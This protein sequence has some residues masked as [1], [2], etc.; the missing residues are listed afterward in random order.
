MRIAA[1]FRRGQPPGTELWDHF[2]R[3]WP[4]WAK[5][6]V[7]Y[8]ATSNGQIGLIPTILPHTV[9]AAKLP[10]DFDEMERDEQQDAMEVRW[11]ISDNIADICNIIGL[12]AVF[13]V[14]SNL[15]ESFCVSDPTAT[16]N[17]E[18]E[19]TMER[20]YR[21]EA[22]LF[23]LQSGPR[24]DPKERSM[25]G[26]HPLLRLF[27][28]LR[29][30]PQHF[31]I[32]RSSIHFIAAHL[33][34]ICVDDE[35][36]EFLY[37]F[38]MTALDDTK[39]QREAVRAIRAFCVGFDATALPR[40]FIVSLFEIYDQK[41]HRLAVKDQLTLIEAMAL[42]ISK[43]RD[44][45][46]ARQGVERLLKK[47]RDHLVKL[48]QRASTEKLAAKD[49]SLDG[50]TLY[51]TVN[52]ISQIFKFFQPDYKAF[53]EGK[54]TDNGGSSSGTGK[55]AENISVKLLEEIW[56][57]IRYILT[58]WTECDGVMEKTTRIIKHVIRNGGATQF[59]ASSLCIEALRLLTDLYCNK[60]QRSSFLYI[61]W[62]YVDEYMENPAAAKAL[63]ETLIKLTQ[64]TFSGPLRDEDTFFVNMDIVE[65]FYELMVQYI[66]K[67][68]RY[69]IQNGQFLQTLFER[70]ICGLL[71]DHQK[72]QEAIT[73][74]F[75][76]CIAM[77][78]HDEQHRELVDELLFGQQGYA[79]RIVLKIL[80]GLCCA[81]RRERAATLADLLNVIFKY[82]RQ[83]IEQMTRGLVA[84]S[85]DTESRDPT[86]FE[87]VDEYFDHRNDSRF[88][89]K[90]AMEWFEANSRWKQQMTF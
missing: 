14:L 69:L 38:T 21:C 9:G 24:C 47:P 57:N 86:K 90:H 82:N 39:C 54:T 44:A 34:F 80:K 7:I 79:Q 29:R 17:F 85:I 83:R 16:I 19:G 36:F 42:L 15:L 41:S 77:A 10:E 60:S 75:A 64:C 12:R 81:V 70:A 32:R 87:F 26:T 50:I 37:K 27:G 23:C 31:L 58:S 56:P 61:V 20:V 35:I 13:E 89:H 1:E 6:Y 67:A 51:D 40:K 4:E 8:P 2:E 74:F 22:I 62:I 5:R 78:S 30:L 65:D 63:M 43:C 53:A 25:N 88:R 59:S 28:Q 66:R 49:V 84:G 33:S 71:L 18:S 76:E 46:V 52:N 72:S 68:H 48:L 45:N 3:P 11:Q 55:M 73:A